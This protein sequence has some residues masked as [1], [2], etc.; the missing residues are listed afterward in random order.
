MHDKDVGNQ[1]LVVTC[2]SWIDEWDILCTDD[3]M[4]KILFLVWAGVIM[5]D[6]VWIKSTRV[7]R[8]ACLNRNHG[9]VSKVLHKYSMR[10]ANLYLWENDCP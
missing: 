8:L 4:V 6:E 1:W 9:M 10:C 2:S 3:M 7:K 5:S